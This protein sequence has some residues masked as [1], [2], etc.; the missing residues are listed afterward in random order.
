[1]DIHP[2]LVRDRHVPISPQIITES[3]SVNEKALR[4]ILE[5]RLSS[6][7]INARPS[8]ILGCVDTQHLRVVARLFVEQDLTIVTEM[9]DWR[10]VEPL[11]VMNVPHH[12]YVH[13]C[14]V[15]AI[16]INGP[17]RPAK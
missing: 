12:V 6:R 13:E 7:S 8:R 15:S 4:F 11:C 16:A 5:P 17:Q 2:G 9:L 3:R 14:S 10:T 1:M